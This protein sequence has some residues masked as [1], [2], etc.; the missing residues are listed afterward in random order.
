MQRRSPWHEKVWASFISERV[1][2]GSFGMA[3]MIMC[4]AILI[5]S[6]KT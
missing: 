3:L 5:Q 2:R 1:W 4:P 6:D